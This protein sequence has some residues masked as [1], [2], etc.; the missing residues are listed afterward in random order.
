IPTGS[1]WDSR[2]FSCAYDSFFTV[3]WNLWQDDVA[4]TVALGS[5]SPEMNA[6][7]RGFQ[8]IHEGLQTLESVRD[9]VRKMLH[10]SSAQMFPVGH[11]YAS[12]SDVAARLLSNHTYGSSQLYCELCGY[13]TEGAATTF[14]L[15]LTII[16][17]TNCSTAT[18][19][20][21]YFRKRSVD[22][23]I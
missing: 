19:L 20:R 4:C 21:N 16:S 2:N 1:L 17:Y 10:A 9:F 6:L 14:F 18:W 3:L 23:K 7:V 15:H 12:V 11:Q 22:P 13:S 8:K 5:L